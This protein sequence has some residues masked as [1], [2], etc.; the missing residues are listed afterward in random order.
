MTLLDAL[1]QLVR[2]LTAKPEKR[3]YIPSLM[4]TVPLY[5]SD[6][7][8]AQQ[9]VDKPNSA[10]WMEWPKFP[11][12]ADHRGQKFYRLPNAKA[13]KTV[14]YIR[15]GGAEQAYI[16]R[17]KYLALITGGT[18]IRESDG[19]DVKQH[20]TD[21]LMYTCSGEYVDGHCEVWVMEWDKKN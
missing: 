11:V 18:L 5:L 8:D 2:V 10:V 14:A 19:S 20:D 12:I 13:D 16:C 9:I 17:D 21:L 6:G 1:H 3:L 7:W 4:I 15:E